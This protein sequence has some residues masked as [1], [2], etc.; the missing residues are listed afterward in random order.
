MAIAQRRQIPA[1]ILTT[2]TT[3]AQ[4]RI[5]FKRKKKLKWAQAFTGGACVTIRDGRQR[6]LQYTLHRL[7][8]LCEQRMR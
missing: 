8:P 3:T 1:K 4:H 5:I 6:Q 7:D 2:T